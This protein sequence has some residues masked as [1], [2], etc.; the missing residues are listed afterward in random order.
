MN[1]GVHSIMYFYYF[2]TN[3]GYRP[4]WAKVVTVLQI[5]QMFVGMGVCAS[6]A[7]YKFGV[8]SGKSPPPP[9][10]PTFPPSRIAHPTTSPPNRR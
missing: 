10:L 8:R 3:C 9:S 4:S 6:V 5:S 1:Y 2:L 7:Y